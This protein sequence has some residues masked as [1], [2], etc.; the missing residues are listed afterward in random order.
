V[1]TVGAR[2][3]RTRISTGRALRVCVVAVVAGLA[4]AACGSSSTPPP[5]TT[6]VTRSSLSTAVSA[7]GSLSAAGQANLGFPKGGQ[8]TSV[9]VRVGDQVAP[10]QVLATVDDA[11]ARQAL[12]QAE[13]QRD[14]QQAN[15]DRVEDGTSV[16]A[17]RASLAQAQRVLDATRRSVDAAG[18]AGGAGAGAP[19]SPSAA[20]GQ[21]QIETARSGVVNAQNALDAAEADRP[22]TI[23]AAEAAVDGAEAAVDGAQR[24][25]DNT[26]LRA[27]RAGTVTTLNGVVGEYVAPSSGTTA[28]APGSDAAIPGAASAASS[29]GAAGAAGAGASPTRPG[30]TQFIMLDDAKSFE[31]VV[32]FE[33]SDAASIATNQRAEV[34]VDAVPDATLA[35]TV[36][37]V[38]PAATPIANVIN[39][40]VT[41][42]LLALDPRLRDGQTARASVI[43]GQ[44]DNV[45]SVPNSAVRRQGTDSSVVVLRAGGRQVPTR[46][47]AG[48]VGADRTQVI[49]GLEE[50]AEVL[51]T[52]GR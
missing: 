3:R 14:A 20:A 11:A 2:S 44:V 45:L 34:S 21:V 23:D 41:I 12:T 29:A 48:L 26:V 46:F 5:R 42:K 33:E 19:S 28:Q 7:T 43:T 50:N 10:G 13:A 17:A 38:A 4:L 32:P 24:D 9:Q 22:H 35:G 8:L 31:V 1:V 37:S 18:G 36:E 30:G 47:T 40:Y 39:Y 15:L 25:V 52:A 27:P 6:R 51:L 49:G 16:D